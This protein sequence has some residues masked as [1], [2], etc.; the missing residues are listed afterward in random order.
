[1]LAAGDM[2]GDGYG[3]LALFLDQNLSVSNQTNQNFG[4]GSTTGI[5]YGRPNDQ[6]PASPGFGLLA[7][8]GPGFDTAAQPLPGLTIASGLTSAA[9][10][11]IAV[12]TTLYAAVQGVGAG[13]T[14]I[15]F[16]QSSD[17][18]NSW[19]D[20][21]DLS[22][23]YAGF[24]TTASPSLAFFDDRL[25]LGFVDSS[26]ALSLASWDPD[27][28]SP[29]NW[30]SPNT[31]ASPDSI[32][33]SGATYD[34]RYSPQL[35]NGGDSLDVVWVDS[36]TG[37]VC[38]AS[39]TTP[40]ATVPWSPIGVGSSVA[41]PAL[42]RLGN[43]LYMAVQ[44]GSGGNAIYWTSSTDD[45]ASWVPWTALPTDITS[46][47]P[48]SLAVVG[49]TLYLSYL[50]DGNNEINIV[51]L[52]AA[53]NT[54]N[55]PY[56]IPGQTAAYASLSCELVGGE[57]QL[58][59]Y[60]VSYDSTNRILKAY[61]STPSSSSNWTSDQQI[62]SDY[63]ASDTSSGVQTASGPIAVSQYGGQTYLAYQGGITS[64]ASDEIYLATSSSSN[65]NI[66]SGWTA[67]ALLDPDTRTGLGLSSD[68]DGLWLTYG[69]SSQSSELQVSL[70]TPN[71]S[72]TVTVQTP[73]SLN[74][75]VGLSNNV[76]TIDAV[77][78]GRGLILAGIN[79]SANSNTVKS[80]LVD[81][82]AVASWTTPNKL[83]QGS[84]PTTAISATAAPSVTWLGGIPVLAVNNNGTIVVYAGNGANNTLNQISSFTAS[85]GVT[86]SSEPVLT[87]TD[88]GLALSYNNSSG[89]I[90]LYRT[91]LI[92]V[93]GSPVAGVTT[94]SV[95]GIDTIEG[96]L[97]WDV[98]TLSEISTAVGSVPLN[99]D[100][101]LMLVNV[102]NDNSQANEIWI[103]AVPNR[104]DSDSLTWL[105]STVQLPGALSGDWTVSQ[106]IGT[107]INLGTTVAT[108]Q[109]L[110]A[111]K[112]VAPPAFA[113][114][115]KNG[116]IYAASLDSSNTSW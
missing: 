30:S 74:L 105:N 19:A 1:M 66:G 3:D 116:V 63:D 35:V 95:G 113:W 13:D 32:Y 47:L 90:T 11:V 102:R 14:T 8:V 85:D 80:S 107:T 37:Q 103:N 39:S 51:S 33:G 26:G 5:F 62:Y 112:A 41:A 87:S 101:T 92:R 2:N 61:T 67:Q 9:A 4:A 28:A 81:L 42:A 88:T 60:Y 111:D 97:V 27:S 73:T 89:T 7:P 55:T 29:A 108:W 110:S 91:D 52:D 79:D 24:A 72:G 86:S 56:Q 36:E 84:S 15:W 10:S 17:G 76:T 25:Y 96:D 83:Q 49:N 57:E 46:V 109:D 99:V 59:V 50:G 6:L 54:W 98:T 21:T 75:P 93:D 18:G 16:S 78:S 58:A 114:D 68:L 94:G 71:S 45:G 20:W 53:S 43:T 64:S 34:S 100:G 31:I 77:G 104:A 23:S 44:A 106:Q 70:L 69:N 82:G 65:L 12:G 22:N 40:T 115:T 38:S 48:P